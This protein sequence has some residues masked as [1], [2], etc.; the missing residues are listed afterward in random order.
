MNSSN[1]NARIA[2]LR[3]YLSLLQEEEKR[4]KWML[5]ST[6]ASHP[7]RADAD[8]DV[9]AITGKLRKAEKELSD[10]ELKS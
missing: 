2:A 10:L 9:S 6:T 3:R 8:R 5:A 4:L 1:T 7:Q